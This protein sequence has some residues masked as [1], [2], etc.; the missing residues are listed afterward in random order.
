MSISLEQLA[1]ILAT[2]GISSSQEEHIL[3]VIKKLTTTPEVNVEPVFEESYI[4]DGEQLFEQ[5]IEEDKE[6]TSN[7]MNHNDNQAYES[8]IE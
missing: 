7:D 2:A 8:L 1:Q 5:E 3:I 4:S 6:E